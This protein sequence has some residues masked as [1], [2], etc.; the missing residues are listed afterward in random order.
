MRKLSHPKSNGRTLEGSIWELSAAKLQDRGLYRTQITII[1][2][3][4]QIAKNYWFHP[5]PEMQY[6]EIKVLVSVKR[7]GNQPK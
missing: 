5:S 6:I 2:I 1:R 3:R 4:N 7:L